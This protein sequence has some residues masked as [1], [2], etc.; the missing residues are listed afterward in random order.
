MLHIW[1]LLRLNLDGWCIRSISKLP[2]LHWF[3]ARANRCN[4]WK[5][6]KTERKQKQWNKTFN[7]G[8]STLLNWNFCCKFAFISFTK[9]GHNQAAGRGCKHPA[10]EVKSARQGNKP[11]HHGHSWPPHPQA[12]TIQKTQ[13]REE[14]KRCSPHLSSVDWQGNLKNGSHFCKHNTD[15]F[16]PWDV[17]MWL[18]CR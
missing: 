14:V 15:S 9:M 16:F 1:C 11:G 18:G 13:R 8:P 12:E 2:N 5:F 7:N 17:R 3:E 6:W 4:P 10:A